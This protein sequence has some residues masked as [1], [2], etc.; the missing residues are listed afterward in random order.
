MSLKPSIKS[1]I[2]AIIVVFIDWFAYVTFRLVGFGAV[3]AIES[4][5]FTIYISILDFA[6]VWGLGYLFFRNKK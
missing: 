3:G 4:I 5:A 6:S 1:L 2:L